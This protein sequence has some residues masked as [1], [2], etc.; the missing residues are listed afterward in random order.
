[1]GK[2]PTVVLYK[3]SESW[4]QACQFA[5]KISP[6]FTNRRLMIFSNKLRSNTFPL[7]DEQIPK[8]I[9]S[10]ISLW[11]DLTTMWAGGN[12]VNPCVDQLE[13]SGNTTH[14]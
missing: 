11:P 3:P 10:F 8:E 13:T 6:I 7:K 4:S 14:G 2:Y 5:A 1:M 9:I 12:D